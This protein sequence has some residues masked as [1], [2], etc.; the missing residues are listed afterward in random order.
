MPLSPRG[1]RLY[2]IQHDPDLLILDEPTSGLDPLVREA[3][4]DLLR[5]AQ[6][7]GRTVFHSSHVLSE[8]DRTCSRVAVL[9]AGR[10]V[11]VSSVA[12]L[13]RSLHRT[14]VVQFRGPAPLMELAAIGAR[15]VETTPRGVVLHV[16]SDLDPR[17]V[18]RHRA[19]DGPQ[20]P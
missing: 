18:L 8:V 19:A 1:A 11:Q 2:E 17:R 7:A 15:V 16:G 20:A 13:R 3:V 10:L 6:A 12:A 9:R 14:M 5:E 4:F